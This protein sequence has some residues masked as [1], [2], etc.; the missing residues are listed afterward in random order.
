MIWICMLYF[1]LFSLLSIEFLQI[2]LFII[3]YRNYDIAL[4][5]KEKTVLWEDHV[6]LPEKEI[7]LLIK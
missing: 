1:L 6:R 4:P 2:I 5:L 7:H 3:F